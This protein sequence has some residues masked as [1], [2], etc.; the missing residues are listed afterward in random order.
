V[1]G[2]NVKW[3]HPKHGEASWGEL[4]AMFATVGGINKRRLALLGWRRS[5][6]AANNP[7]NVMLG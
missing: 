3:Y 6:A 5:E 4:K 2:D 1:R 7:V